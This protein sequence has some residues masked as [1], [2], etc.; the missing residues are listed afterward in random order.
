MKTLNS[1]GRLP[2]AVGILFVSGYGQVVFHS[3]EEIF[4]IAVEGSSGVTFGASYLVTTTT[5]ESK[6]EKV[7]GTASVATQNRP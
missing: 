3:G 7:A 2:L 6:N 4:T 1:H 5:G